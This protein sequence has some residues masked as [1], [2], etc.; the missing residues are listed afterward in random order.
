VSAAL[1][2]GPWQHEP[3]QAAWLHHPSGYP[4]L[5]KRSHLGVW[6][7]YVGVPADHPYHERSYWTDQGGPD[8]DVHGGPTYAGYMDGE[9]WCFGFD[10]AHWMDLVPMALA[11]EPLRTLAEGTYRDF[12][13]VQAEVESLAQQLYDKRNDPRIE[14]EAFDPERAVEE[15]LAALREFSTEEFMTERFRVERES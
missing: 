4:C 2:E 12:E 1:P 9:W 14:R 13:Y 10:C 6:C 8:V 15:A 7:G 11:Y 3:D 5:M